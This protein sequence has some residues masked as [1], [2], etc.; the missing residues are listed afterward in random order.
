MRT[1]RTTLRVVGALVS[2]VVLLGV[3]FFAWT[4]VLPWSANHYGFALPGG[5]DGMPFRI[6]YSGRTYATHGLCA[7]AGWCEGELNAEITKN[8]L[9]SQGE[10]PLTQVTSLSTFL[11]SSHPVLAHVPPAGM[12]TMELYV[13]GGSDSY[14]AYTL[15]GGP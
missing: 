15:E 5:V 12:T 4:V 7:R 3:A 9:Q 8:T 14:I 11:G 13:P 2:L 6:H 10:W 1:N